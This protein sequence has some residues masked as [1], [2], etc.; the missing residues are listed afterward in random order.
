MQGGNDRRPYRRTNEHVGVFH[1]TTTFDEREQGFEKLFA[2]D[3]EL[4]FKATVRRDR[5]LGLWA[6]DKLG[7]SG[8]AAEAYAKELIVA[9]IEDHDVFAKLRRDFD[10]KGVA[11]SDEQIQRVTQELMAR[12][13]AEV[14]AGR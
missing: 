3:E 1:M 2:H 10:A 5:L 6:A 8:P 4:R 11:Q 12:A 13:I 14:K 7:V 9:E